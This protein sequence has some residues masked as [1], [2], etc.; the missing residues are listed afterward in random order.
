[1]PNL[2][3]D[4]ASVEA[5][6]TAQVDFP[7]ITKSLDSSLNQISH[8]GADLEN[9]ALGLHHCRDSQKH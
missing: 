8:I 5:A 4:T 7:E 3:R 2:R 9:L 6:V 1:M